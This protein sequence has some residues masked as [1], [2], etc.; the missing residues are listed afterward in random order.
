MYLYDVIINGVSE[1][2][3]WLVA[4]DDLIYIGMFTGLPKLARI[5]F[6]ICFNELQ[7]VSPERDLSSSRC[8]HGKCKCI[9]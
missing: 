1:V 2:M 6:L 8:C 5:I 3:V 4:Q 9:L 7:F